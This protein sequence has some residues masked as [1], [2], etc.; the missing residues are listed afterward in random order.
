MGEAPPELDAVGED[1]NVGEDG[2]PVVV[3][4]ELDSNRQ[5]TKEAKQP[6]NQK[7]RQPNTQVASQMSPTVAKPSR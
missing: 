3:K 6:E 1:L 2:P 7:G 4:P 5:S